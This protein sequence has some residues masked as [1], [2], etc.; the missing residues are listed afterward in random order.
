[1][2]ALVRI[3]FS[4]K[5]GEV[6]IAYHVSQAP[7]EMRHLSRELGALVEKSGLAV[8]ALRSVLDLQR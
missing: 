2:A 3:L 8:P 5:V 7:D 4:T 1:V 6:G